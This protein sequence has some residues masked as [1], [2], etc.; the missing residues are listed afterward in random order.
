MKRLADRGSLRPPRRGYLAKCARC[1]L[2]VVHSKVTGLPLEQHLRSKACAAA[3]S[4]PPALPPPIAVLAALPRRVELPDLAIALNAARATVELRL[5][6]T[7]ALFIQ[8][9]AYADFVACD[10]TFAVTV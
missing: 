10:L 5:D 9:M 3:S 1:G 4:P 2:E 8:P 7:Y 6:G